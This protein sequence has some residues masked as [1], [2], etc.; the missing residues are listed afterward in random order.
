MSS[1]HSSYITHIPHAARDDRILAQQP[2]ELNIDQQAPTVWLLSCTMCGLVF[3]DMGVFSAHMLY[4]HNKPNAWS[5]MAQEVH[6][7][8][9]DL[10]FQSMVT[11]NRHIAECHVAGDASVCEHGGKTSCELCCLNRHDT[12][13]HRSELL[14]SSTRPVSLILE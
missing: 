11:L 12:S 7:R 8:E 14:D 10:T 3:H 1:S 13:E 5:T 4:H 9:C 6:C 2:Y